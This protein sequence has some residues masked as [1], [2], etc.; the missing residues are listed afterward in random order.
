MK[1]KLDVECVAAVTCARLDPSDQRT[2][3]ILADRLDMPNNELDTLL[4]DV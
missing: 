1:I 2:P 4:P 3:A